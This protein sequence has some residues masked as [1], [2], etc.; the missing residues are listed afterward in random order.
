MNFDANITAGIYNPNADKMTAADPTAT[1]T[2][3]LTLRDLN[4]LKKLRAFRRLESLKRRDRLE[5]IYGSS[6]GDNVI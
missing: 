6:D 5:T 1:R 3:V 4:K 2:A